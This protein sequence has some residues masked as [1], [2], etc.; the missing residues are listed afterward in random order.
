MDF[1]TVM[2]ELE[3]LGT[4]Q[5]KK[6]YKNHGAHEPLFG[7]ATG[8]MKPLAKKIKKDYELSMK[9]YATDNYDAAYF[10]GMIA[11][12]KKMSAED[13]ESWME[14]A[15]CHMMSDYVVAVTLAETD[16]AQEVS[17]RWIDSGKELYMSA[18]WCCYCWLLGNRPD[19]YFDK[20]KLEGMLHR[21]SREI[22]TQPNRT[23]YAMND[24]VITVG[25]S[26]LPLH[27]E[28]LKIAE[29]IGQVEVSMGKTSCKTPL[30]FDYINRAVEKGRLGFKRKNVR[31]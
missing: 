12:P 20:S 10:A 15:Y 28:A 21:V 4:E 19:A 23:R 17:D 8:A 26:Y 18:G 3:A 5:N 1:E 25:I 31:C 14:T 6:I 27:D 7:V 11:D 22:H 16:F 9:L 24:F 29:Q 13:F 30:A 2:R